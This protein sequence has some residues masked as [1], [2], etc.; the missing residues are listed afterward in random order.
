MAVSGSMIWAFMCT[1]IDVDGYYYIKTSER[2]YAP[3]DRVFDPSEVVAKLQEDPTASVWCR[4]LGTNSADVRSMW[5]NRNKDDDAP[6][7]GGT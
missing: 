2:S 1:V 3:K 5:V 4:L 7:M 6:A